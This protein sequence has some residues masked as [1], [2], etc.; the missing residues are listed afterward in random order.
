VAAPQPGACAA[1]SPQGR[2]SPGDRTSTGSRVEAPPDLAGARHTRLTPAGTPLSSLVAPGDVWTRGAA[3]GARGWRNVSRN[4]RTCLRLHRGTG[5]LAGADKVDCRSQSTPGVTGNLSEFSPPA[6]ERGACPPL[7]C[8][9]DFSIWKWDRF[10][11]TTRHFGA[12]SPVDPSGTSR[13]YI[14]RVF[15]N[16]AAFFHDSA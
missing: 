14:T 3:P 12:A 16:R 7:A 8:R 10:T 11:A 15:G 2:R 4:E 1:R 6:G 9:S 5:P 13:I